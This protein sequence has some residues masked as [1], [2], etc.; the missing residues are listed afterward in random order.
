MLGGVGR[1]TLLFWCGW[2]PFS[3]LCGS[4]HFPFYFFFS[5]HCLNLFLRIRKDK[6]V[7]LLQKLIRVPNI[8]S[9]KW[10]NA[11]FCEFFII[12]LWWEWY[13]ENV[14]S[15]NNGTFQKL[16]F[17]VSPSWNSFPHIICVIL[18]NA[19]FTNIVSL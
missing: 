9:L 18:L 14:I 6:I 5:N 13:V 10:S 12:V 3:F 11:F 16:L 8:I 4:T 7:K 1:K 19:S 15:T 17:N 2:E